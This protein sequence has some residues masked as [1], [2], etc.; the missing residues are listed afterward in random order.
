MNVTELKQLLLEELVQ[1]EEEGCNVSGYRERISAVNLENQDRAN[2]ILLELEQEIADLKPLKSHYVEPSTLNEIRAARPEGPKKFDISLSDQQLKDRI[3]GAWLG[4][5]A[6]C[7]L[8]KPVEGW[9]KERIERYLKLANAYPLNSYFP[10][11]SPLPSDP[12]LQIRSKDLLLGNI[13]RSVRDD[14]TDYTVMGLHTLED[15]GLDFG[16]Q[17]VAGQ[18]LT[19]LPYN[20][21]YTAE[22]VAYRNLVDGL[23][24]P[25]SAT[26]R[27]PYRE[28]IGAQI[29]ADAWGYVTPGF[30]ELGAEFAFRDAFVSHVKNG[31]YGEM[32]MSAIISA[33]LISDSLTEAIEAGLAE[34]P[35][36]SRLREA[37]EDVKKWSQEHDDWRDAWTKVIEKYGHYHPVHT[38]N[39]AALVLLG[40]LYGNGDYEKSVAIAVMGGLDTDCN[41]AT[42]GS[43]VGAFLG[44]Q[45]LPQKWIA[46]LNDRLESAL[47]GFT[48]NRISDLAERTFNIAKRVLEREAQ[49]ISQ[50]A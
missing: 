29:R 8:G 31:I 23:L 42:A 46:P 14:D 19:H 9:T 22:R 28:W 5:C 25:E 34:I 36:N 37:V 30:P 48:L 35:A 43:I 4:R 40:L 41:G 10:E 32:L 39:N 27:N 44:A 47:V 12:H 49:D 16:S 2:A 6:G 15:D 20:M 17:H 18:W 24:P 26:Y 13:T 3:Y 21:V 38:I 45:K 50:I 7:M 11:I 33:A 1:R